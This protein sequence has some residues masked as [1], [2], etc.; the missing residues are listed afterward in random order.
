MLRRVYNRATAPRLGVLAP[1]L[2]DEGE[3]VLAYVDL[4]FAEDRRELQFP[5]LSDER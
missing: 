2:D 1:E 3:L 5:S 4:P